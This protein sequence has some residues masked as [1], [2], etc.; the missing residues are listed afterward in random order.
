M[1]KKPKLLA[2]FLNLFSKAF[3]F[4][5]IFIGAKRLLPE[6][7]VIISQIYLIF[8]V[9]SLFQEAKD[10]NRRYCKRCSAKYDYNTDIS[11]DVLEE[12]ANGSVKVEFT[13]VCPHCGRERTFTR[14]FY[15]KHKDG[16]HYRLESLVKK[17][18]R[19]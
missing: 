2:H 11:W 3:L 9:F 16:I 17:F 18:F 6:G 10:I 19:K 1:K 12:R 13:C 15:T 8:I 4:A 7:L 5:L 14:V